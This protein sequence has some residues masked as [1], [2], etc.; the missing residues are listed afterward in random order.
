MISN[1]WVRKLQ[2][3]N[4]LSNF[5][6]SLAPEF[7]FV[8]LLSTLLWKFT[9]ILIW[10]QLS[11]NLCTHH[12]ASTVANLKPALFHLYSHPHDPTNELF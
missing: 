4:R 7:V 1:L 2:H 5:P 10:R 3:T 6:E 12:P 9:N 11:V 8:C